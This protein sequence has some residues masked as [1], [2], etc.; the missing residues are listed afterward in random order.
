MAASRFQEGFGNWTEYR[1]LPG[2][3]EVDFHHDPRPRGELGPPVPYDE[4]MSD[5]WQK[6]IDA[7][8]LAYTDPSVHY[9]IFTHG[10]ST[11]RLGKTTARSQV[12]NA[13]RSKQATP[14]I[15]RKR[16]IQHDSVFVAALK[17]RNQV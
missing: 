2:V 8:E 1:K 13:M 9:I 15:D 4:R 11:S 5:V 17:Q 16:C 12:R 10:R 6:A 7:L 14:Y 3:I